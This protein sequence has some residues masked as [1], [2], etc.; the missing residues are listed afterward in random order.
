[1]IAIYIAFIC[2]SKVSSEIASG[3]LRERS[4][5]SSWQHQDFT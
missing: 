1:M 4:R 3:T 2:V 5:E